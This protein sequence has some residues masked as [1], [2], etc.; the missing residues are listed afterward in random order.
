MA[1]SE[2]LV[3][4]LHDRQSLARNH[5]R[6]P[7]PRRPERRLGLVKPIGKPRCLRPMGGR[8]GRIDAGMARAQ[9][10][11]GRSRNS[12]REYER[13]RLEAA[14]QGRRFMTYQQAQGRL[15]KAVAGVAAG[16]VTDESSRFCR[17][18]VVGV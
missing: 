14:G 2:R 13:R 1:K 8:V 9:R 7:F 3:I 10:T 4:R 5:N 16:G 6:A 18:R 17:P 15:R 11:K 12:M